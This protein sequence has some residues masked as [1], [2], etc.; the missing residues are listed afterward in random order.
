M[1]IFVLLVILLTI[2]L[3]VLGVFLPDYRLL[4]WAFPAGYGFGSALTQLVMLLEDKL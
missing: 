1:R 4:L 3:W 2:S